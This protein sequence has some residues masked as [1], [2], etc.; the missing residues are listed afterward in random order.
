MT[1]T[2]PYTPPNTPNTHTRWRPPYTCTQ[3]PLPTHSASTGLNW[4]VCRWYLLLGT[5]GPASNVPLLLPCRG[6]VELRGEDGGRIFGFF[7]VGSC[8][9]VVMEGRAPPSLPG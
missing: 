6:V 5:Q 4:F 7:V 3:Q 9:S 8:G 1:T 2:Q